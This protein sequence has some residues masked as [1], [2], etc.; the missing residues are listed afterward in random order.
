MNVPHNQKSLVEIRTNRHGTTTHDWVPTIHKLTEV[1]RK[2][3]VFQLS[4]LGG[5]G[6]RQDVAS[7]RVV[8][9]HKPERLVD[10]SVIMEPPHHSVTTIHALT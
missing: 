10:R 6:S 2:K 3:Q 8:A 9:T 5:N 7:F 4:D 1:E